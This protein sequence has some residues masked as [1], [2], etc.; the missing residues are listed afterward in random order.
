MPMSTA[1][2]LE[3]I[4]CRKGRISSSTNHLSRYSKIFPTH[5]RELTLTCRDK[6]VRHVS[7]KPK[8]TLPCDRLQ[9]GENC[10]SQRGRRSAGRQIWS[11]EPESS[12]LTDSRSDWQTWELCSDKAPARQRTQPCFVWGNKKYD[13]CENL[14]CRRHSKRALSRL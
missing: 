14:N 3:G 1:G 4:C 7:A 9:E 12:S 5:T 6:E 2:S 10:D 13:N 11:E 8:I